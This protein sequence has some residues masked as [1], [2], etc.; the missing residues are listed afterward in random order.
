MI[1]LVNLRRRVFGVIPEQHHGEV[2]REFDKYQHEIDRMSER[3]DKTGQAS[4][5]GREIQKL[6]TTNQHGDDGLTIIQWQAV[7]AKAIENGVEDWTMKV[8]SNL[9]YR[10]NMALMEEEKEIPTD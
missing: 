1:N 2:G 8:D 4:L 9:T 7:K 10:E 5:T 3:P 6:N